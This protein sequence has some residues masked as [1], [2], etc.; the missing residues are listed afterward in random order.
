MMYKESDFIAVIITLSI[1]NFAGK[2][3]NVNVVLDWDS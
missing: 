3:N 1:L 2:G